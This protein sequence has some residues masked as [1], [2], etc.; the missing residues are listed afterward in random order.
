MVHFDHFPVQVLIQ[1]R[2]NAILKLNHCYYE[3]K[4]YNKNIFRI[5]N[6]SVLARWT[7]NNV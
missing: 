1:Q 3:L 7:A 6:L 4:H 5:P 2:K